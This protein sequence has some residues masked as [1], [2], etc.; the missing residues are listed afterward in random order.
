MCR[1]EQ[2]RQCAL[3]RFGR[4]ALE[5][6]LA[7]FD[8]ALA[9]AADEATVESAHDQQG[10]CADRPGRDGREIGR[11]PEFVVRR[12]TPKHAFLAA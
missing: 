5:D 9:L 6:A 7:L 4:I 2:L 8:E 10:G 12:R 3:D 1:V 11:L